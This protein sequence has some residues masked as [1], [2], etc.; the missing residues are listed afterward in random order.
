MNRKNTDNLSAKCNLKDIQYTTTFIGQLNNFCTG[1][2]N[3]EF[4]SIYDISAVV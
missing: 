1:Y 4:I 3:Y 2:C